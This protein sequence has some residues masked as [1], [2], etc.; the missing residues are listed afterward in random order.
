M[1]NFAFGV[2]AALALVGALLDILRRTIP[3]WL[4]LLILIGGAIVLAADPGWSRIWA[5]LAHFII[6]LLVGMILYRFRVWGGGDAKFY[7]AI[8]LWFPVGQCA[9]LASAIALAGAPLVAIFGAMA[10]VSARPN[11]SRSL[12]YGVAIAAA[13]LLIG[14]LNWQGVDWRE[15][16]QFAAAGVG[17]AF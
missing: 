14:Y 3:N 9:I 13:A 4:N 11:W 16:M 1:T 8:A 7:A 10:L 2:L 17:E 15:I 6:A 12:P 5:H